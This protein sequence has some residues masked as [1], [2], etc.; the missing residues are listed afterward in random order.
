MK[1]AAASTLVVLLVLV[2]AARA[3]LLPR[4]RIVVR[5]VSERSDYGRVDSSLL[6]RPIEPKS[7]EE[8]PPAPA[9]PPLFQ[10]PTSPP[11]GFTG[12]SSVAPTEVPDEE[13]HFIPVEDR[14]RIGMPEW[15]R[16]G[17]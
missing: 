8:Q 11:A 1:R 16:Y 14:W 9:V 7:V 5:G 4:P 12:R 3:Q 10:V 6:E 17:K 2:G 15:D 13:G